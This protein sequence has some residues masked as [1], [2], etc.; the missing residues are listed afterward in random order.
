MESPASSPPASSPLAVPP[1]A[2][3]QPQSPPRPPYAGARYLLVRARADRR[4]I[5]GAVAGGLF[6]DLAVHSGPATI[7]VTAWLIV[8]AAALLL[9]GRLR[10]LQSKL[11]IGAAPVLGLLFTLRSSA[12]VLLPAG[13]AIL[14]LFF[15]GVSLGADGSG[16]S[17]TL[18][19][20]LNR[21]G[22]V[23]GHLVIAPGMFRLEGRA[24]ATDR[25]ARQ[26]T[27][28]ARGLLLGVPVVLLVG[29]LLAG[30]DP[31]FRSW[32]DLG[33]LARHL[34]FVLIGVWFVVGL[35]RASSA[36][37]PAAPLQATPALG[38]VEASL[39][40]G[41]LCALY[42]AFVGAQFVALSNAGHRILVTRGLTYAQYARSGFFQLLACAA[43]TLLVL[44]SVRA[45]VK[46]SS[47][48][49][50]G[51]SA[52]TVVLTI[53]VVFVAFRRLELL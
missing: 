30:A 47:K 21:L 33:P 12:W 52:L 26:A 44:L 16:L 3:P 34:V 31:I 50:T 6:F 2:A 42:A 49:V 35:A 37:E 15:I 43:I 10:G 46:S 28:I 9:G 24:T 18:P 45:C 14:F 39:V 53:G 8:V 11:L 22:T 40:L 25:A 20:I 17:A 13:C 4:L 38:P 29:L 36:K 27:A 7:A 41:G 1:P 32:F 51:L 5:I 48:A 19:A 23:A